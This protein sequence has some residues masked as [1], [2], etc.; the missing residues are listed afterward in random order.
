M[1][2]PRSTFLTLSS[3]VVLAVGSFAIAFPQAL[4]DSKG[5][6]LPNQA[7]VVWVRELGVAILALGVLLF[8]VRRHSPSPTLR[9]IFYCN[10]LLQLGLLPVEIAAY[11]D[12]VITQLAGIVPNSLL[13]L[14]L[15]AGFLSFAAQMRPVE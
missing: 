13:H 12:G 14:V 1:R 9:A 8:A 6:P 5:V 4:L 11:R 10:A 3:A 7:A 2:V 15:A